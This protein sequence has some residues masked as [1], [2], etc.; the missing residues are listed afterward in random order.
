MKH[1][2]LIA[3]LVLALVGTFWYSHSPASP[4]NELIGTWFD[5]STCNVYYIDEYNNIYIAWDSA[6]DGKLCLQTYAVNGDTI[7]L[8]Y[9]DEWIEYWGGST[10]ENTSTTHTFHITDNIC[11]LDSEKWIQKIDIDPSATPSIV[12]TWQLSTPSYDTFSLYSDTTFLDGDSITFYADG[13]F[14]IDEDDHGNYEIVFDGDG[15]S[16]ITNGYHEFG[17]YSIRQE[18]NELLF[19][20]INDTLAYSFIRIE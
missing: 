6:P 17:P 7:T 20:R 13:T 2:F 14:W 5:P 15:L 8:T 16:M 4:S 18:G 10:D 9:S 19:I 3:I 1:K 12:G 11:Y